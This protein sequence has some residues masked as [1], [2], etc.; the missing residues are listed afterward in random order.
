MQ[1]TILNG[2]KTHLLKLFCSRL[3]C[4]TLYFMC[5]AAILATTLSKTGLKS[6]QSYFVISLYVWRIVLVHTKCFYILHQ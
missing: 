1:N 6:L 3:T 2:K 5:P 4:L